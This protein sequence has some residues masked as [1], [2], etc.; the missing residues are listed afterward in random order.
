MHMAMAMG[1]SAF[2][3]I[4]KFSVQFSKSIERWYLSTY[5]QSNFQIITGMISSES[6]LV[7]LSKNINPHLAKGCVEKWLLEV[8]LETDS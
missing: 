5:A 7:K 1:W 3:D 4:A 6:E 2:L 8:S